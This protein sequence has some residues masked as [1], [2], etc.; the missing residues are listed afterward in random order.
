MEEPFGYTQDSLMGAHVADRILEVQNK[1]SCTLEFTQVAYND[2]FAANIQGLMY[3]EDG[4]DL[5][6]SFNN[7]Q[8]RKALGTGGEESAMQDLLAL[9]NI[10]NFWNFNKWGNITSRETMMAGGTF[11]GVTPALWVDCTPLPY[12]QVVYNKDLVE[13]FGITDPQ[14]FWEKE[15]WDRDNMLDLITSCYDDSQAAPIWGMTGTLAHMIRATS[16]TTGISLVEIEAINSDGSVDWNLGLMNPD[17]TEALQWLKNSLKV[18]GKYFN[19]GS[20]D[21]KTWDSQ[22]PFVNGQTVF[23]LT[24]PGTLFGT[25][26][27]SVENFGLITWA[28]VDPNTLTGYYENCFSVAIPVFAKSAYESAYLAYDLFEG[29]NGIETYEDVIAY[30][31]ETYFDSDIDVTCLV[32]EGASLQYS[33]WPNGVDIM[34][35]NL[36]AGFDNASSMKT[37]IEK[38]E[39]C[40]DVPIETYMVPNA[41]KLEQYRQNG[42]FN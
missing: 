13:T 37:L 35:V 16:L 5:V 40:V 39:H 6:F 25:I 42:F 1:Y 29:M 26:V 34:W 23:C 9:D 27:T 31:R 15:E 10:L 8:L 2:N 21:W 20:S 17:V 19:N 38:N 22:T 28:G 11:Y 33:Y 41:V 14:E 3:A 18:N 24:R 30:Y 7:A 4:G 36:T 32:R 12:Y